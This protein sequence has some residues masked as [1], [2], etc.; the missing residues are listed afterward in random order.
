MRW[1]PTVA[2]LVFALTS[3]GA[4][5]AGPEPRRV[6]VEVLCGR[7]LE[8]TFDR[9]LYGSLEGRE[10]VGGP[11]EAY[12][13]SGTLSVGYVAKS[14]TGSSR[15]EEAIAVSGTLELADS[16]G[17]Y[18]SAHLLAADS[19]GRTLEM[20]GNYGAPGLYEITW[21]GVSLDRPCQLSVT[22]DQPLP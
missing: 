17:A 20:R 6:H 2:F 21:N 4:A 22:S 12:E 16:A 7:E 15:V 14:E 13:V 19:S 18:V 1:V 3:G 5:L 11:A 9:Y 10:L 8:P